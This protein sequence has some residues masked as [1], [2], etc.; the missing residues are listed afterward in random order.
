[1]QTVDVNIESMAPP[2]KKESVSL[3]QKFLDNPDLRYIDFNKTREKHQ[4]HKSHEFTWEIDGYD[5]VRSL[6]DEMA[7][8]LKARYEYIFAM[9]NNKYGVK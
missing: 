9:T 2:K 8:M 7:E 4:F 1:M 6:N 3:F 5:C